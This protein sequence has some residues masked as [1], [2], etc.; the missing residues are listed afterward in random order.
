[1]NVFDLRDTLIGDYQR[2]ARSFTNIRADDIRT[3]VDEAY[4]SGRYW[5][6]PLVQLNPR[7]APGKRID[8]LVEE[9]ALH[10]D[11]ARI[12]RARDPRG[13][14]QDGAP[15]SLYRHQ[16]EALALASQQHS[17]V[18]TTGTGS[19]KSLCF[20]LP[21]INAILHAKATDSRPRTRAIIIYPMNALANS[22]FEELDKFPG[23][24]S[25]QPITYAR[26]TGQESIEDRE[27]IRHE[28][29]D[30]LL[31]NFMMLE[32]LMTRQDELDRAVIE[33]CQGLEFLVLDE[34]HTYR[35]RQGADVAMLVRRVRERLA[36]DQLICIGTSATMASEG[37]SA[38]RNAVVAAT[39]SR[40]FAT[41]IAA[42][43]VV[44]ETLMR[45]TEQTETAQTVQPRLATAISAGLPAD[46]PD[47]ALAT[48]PLAIWAETT[49]GLAKDPGGKWTRAK[50]Q[51]IADAV[52]ALVKASG[53]SSEVCQRTLAAFL[54]VAARSE[55][56][57]TKGETASD[58]PFFAFKLHQFISGAGTV[59]TTLE[60]PGT[61]RVELDGQA[62]LPQHPDIRL[63]STHFCRECGHEYHPVSQRSTPVTTF[64][65]R[66]IDD[67][68][69]RKPEGDDDAAEDAEQEVVGFLTLDPGVTDPEF[70]FG[71][72]LE[73]YPESWLE[74]TRAGVPRLRKS[75]K[76]HRA[77][78]VNVRPNGETGSDGHPAWFLPGKFRFCLRCRVT[79]GAQGKDVNRLAS[80]SA[81][82][83][84]SATTVLTF[85][86]LRWMHGVQALDRYSR[87][88]LA[89]SDNRQDAAL[90]AG[91]FN[92]FIFVALLRGGFLAALQAA[93]PDGLS[94][95]DLGS[96]M[97]R[98]FGFDRGISQEEEVSDS[99]RALWLDDPDVGPARLEEGATIL[100]KVLA[101]RVWIDQR[102]GWRYTN[103]TLEQLGLVAVS[104]P[105]L[106]ALVQD[107]TAMA[108]ASQLLAQ[109]TPACRA[110]VFKCVLDFLRQGLAVHVPQF[111]REELEA[112]QGQSQRN[113]R[114]PWALGRDEG[115]RPPRW[116]TI[117]PPSS[118]TLRDEELLLRGGY[119][120]TLGRDLRRPA[121]WNAPA[122]FTI[123]KEEYESLIEGILEVLRHQGLV[124]RES[125]TIFGVPG[126]RLRPEAVRYH[127]AAPIEHGNAF[128]IDF[129]RTLAVQI[130]HDNHP[131]FGF[132][133]REHT[134]QVKDVRRKLREQRFRF[135]AKERQELAT[136]PEAR[137]EG[138][139]TT[140]LPL[141]FCSPTM[142]L[143][144]D[145]SEL[146]AVYLRN[147]PPTPANYAQ[148]S[149]RAGRSGMA[150]LVVTYCASRS[151]HDQYFFRH[152]PAMVH[153]EVR[154]PLLDLA[155]RELVESHLQA[156]WLASSKTP[157]DPAI[158]KVLEIGMPEKPVKPEFLTALADP[159]AQADA[160][161]RA[162]RILGMLDDALTPEQAPW[163]TD[164][165]R[166]AAETIG[167]ACQSFDEAFHRWRSLYRTAEYQRSRARQLLDDHTQ[168]RDVHEQA[169]RDQNVAE[170]LLIALREGTQRSTGDFYIYR[171]L[172]TEGFL[173][174]YNFPRLPLLACIPADKLGSRAQAYVQRPRFLALAEFGPRALV[175]HEGRA[176]RVVK[177]RLGGHTEGV[178][179]EVGLLPVQTVRICGHCGG[180]HFDNQA[181]G[182]HACGRSLAT[183][184]IV[185]NLLRI[186]HVDTIAAERITADDE[187]R[188]RQ[189][190]ELQTT[191][192][193]GERYGV[194]DVR[195]MHATDDAGTIV[196]LRYGAGATIT[197]VN[198]GLR[199]RKE[200][201]IYGYF[202]NP[203]SGWWTK[204]YDEDG[205]GDPLPGTVTPQRVVP[206][207]QE[208]KNALH[209]ELAAGA[210]EAGD[211]AQAGATLQHA[212]RRAIEIVYQLEEG[213][214]LV[215]P[216]PDRE[217]RLGMLFYEATEGGAGVLTRLV[218]EPAALARV[219][220]AALRLMHLC[221]PESVD[222]PLPDVTTLAD[223]PDACVAG[224]Y[225]CLLS[226]FN[227]PDHE[228]IDRRNVVTREVL[229]RLACVKTTVATVSTE[230]MTRDS[231]STHAST[232]GW[233][234]RW[235]TALTASGLTLPA[236]TLQDAGDAQV[237]RWPAVYAAA[238][239]PDTP[240]HI[241]D[242][243]DEEGT[244]LFVFPADESR[245]EA[246][247][248]RLA[249]YLRPG[250]A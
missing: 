247:F 146:N 79:Y 139:P 46:I 36:N 186:E 207:V 11:C 187:E 71:G 25:P 183:A 188:Q 117:K 228:L 227:Q 135:G 70:V 128:Y 241:R 12:F 193:W 157:L 143:G 63:Y 47:A 216:L 108:R 80:L 209:L 118:M 158:A 121:L 238:V 132:E 165:R 49:L 103:P 130:N 95:D 29:P 142:E 66:S 176:Y 210:G 225:R 87:K 195:V 76:P 93:S 10:R 153:G 69:L 144:V 147:A 57:R 78:Q 14:G 82:G 112:L 198:L 197:R 218:H 230:E 236:C 199:R 203:R 120:T 250:S 58:A 17:Y 155:N 167:N 215:E 190:F 59:Y 4:A 152:P 102:R 122:G 96:A 75:Y 23:R 239:L 56:E 109:A 35:G 172:A 244:T 84:S 156:V 119:Q 115:L 50:P 114:S 1:M 221:I 126:W 243:L 237:P 21:L 100:R 217:R 42:T 72:T 177:V 98:A 191:F 233:A 184:T 83:R 161:Q 162:V 53:C 141:L 33:N 170:D 246:I 248:R 32:L 6:E 194:P 160:V 101:Y 88:L 129:F 44:T 231:S 226:Y 182:C 107:D 168:P 2:F 55:K 192:H 90:Q 62:W 30:I 91:H 133:A 201:K 85:S 245:W 232:R 134:A 200:R 31:T 3:Q 92:D 22:Q 145:I 99:H 185:R 159:E 222:D 34:L 169:R 64:Y 65:P 180:G 124:E 223:V 40:L 202:L 51:T 18:V 136:S 8:Q 196:T 104:Y 163:F 219:A 5:P 106:A 43:D 206:F 224:C 213:E 81:E 137:E 131:L 220:R 123:R 94:L 229:V 175:Y 52:A 74:F 54:L 189:G 125:H 19:G 61:R 140:F 111:A 179:P 174:G 234:A 24:L 15:L 89:F 164:P 68:P 154:A 235:Q 77:Q 27:K 208:Q 110:R 37:S 20:F 127:P 45:A 73:E 148:R 205:G 97:Q 16:L 67:L 105:R 149:G 249:T 41:P 48:N 212:L 181:N 13:T 7:F 166:F 86:A 9:G 242:R 173:P 171:Y 39:A 178:A 26:Y 138:E 151:P 150:A 28:P 204:E 240:Q 38:E 211:T 116:L 113:L 214:L 60:T